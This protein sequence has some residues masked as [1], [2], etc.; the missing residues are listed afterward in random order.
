MLRGTVRLN[1]GCAGQLP[2]LG[3]ALMLLSHAA[4]AYG[5]RGAQPSTDTSQS[6]STEAAKSVK[7]VLLLFGEDERFPMTNELAQSIRAGL[8][9]KS[10]NHIE[11]YTE[12]LDRALISDTAYEKELVDLWQRKYHDLQ[13]DLIIV[14]IESALSLLSKHRAELFPA[15]PIVFSVLLQADLSRTAV[16]TNATGVWSASPYRAT[17]ELALTLHPATKRVILVYGSTEFEKRLLEVTQ[18]ELREYAGQ[19]EIVYKTDLEIEQLQDCLADANVRE[20][21]PTR[22]EDQSLHALWQ[23]VGKSF[24]DDA[25]IAECR[26]VI[27]RLPAAGIRFQTQVVET[28]LKRFKMRVAVAIVVKPDGV[29]IP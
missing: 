20:N 7:R 3:I 19:L 2:V 23:A 9:D 27:S 5:A 15:T 25:T 28:F 26:K 12:Y 21:R 29:E 18:N 11:Y 8:N 4:I 24:F 17:L 1:R 22:V 13:P 14:C 6:L 10:A 16:P